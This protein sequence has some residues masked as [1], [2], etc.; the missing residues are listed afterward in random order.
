MGNSVKSI[1]LIIFFVLVLY[2][3]FSYGQVI[4]TICYSDSVIIINKDEKFELTFGACH[5]CG[6]R[7]FLESIDTT[8][9]IPINTINKTNTSFTGNPKAGGSVFEIWTLKGIK[10]GEYQLL[11][12]YKRFGRIIQKRE[13]LKVIIQ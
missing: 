1:R 6:A 8:G 13:M 4:E 7:W 11:F 5:D 10:S 9:I 2:S 12:Y 3:C